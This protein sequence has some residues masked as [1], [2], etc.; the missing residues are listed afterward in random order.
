M[1]PAPGLVHTTLWEFDPN[2]EDR[3]YYQNGEYVKVPPF[4]G[5]RTVEFAEPIGVQ[6]V[7]YV[8]HPE[9]LTIPSAIPSL[10]KMEIRGTW[11]SETMELLRFMNSFG[12]YH[13]EPTEIKHQTVVP[14]DWMFEYLLT[15]P[16][17]KE[18][19]IWAYGLVV[20]VSGLKKRKRITHIFRTSHPPMQKWG[21]KDAYARNVGYP[22][23]IGAQMLA[24]GQVKSAG[25]VAPESAFDALSFIREL[26]K[27]GIK[28]SHRIKRAQPSGKG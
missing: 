16:E 4:S 8:P 24:K 2:I 13:R 11:P 7:Y 5:E 9:P 23:S 26:A 15:R 25:V 12:V 14:Y 21:G 6:K 27:R 1:A 22:L 18:T 28:V 20:E 19:A 10:K 3:V 17:A